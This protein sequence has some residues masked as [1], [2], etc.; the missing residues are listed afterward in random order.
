MLKSDVTCFADGYV[1]L[2]QLLLKDA[3]PS[4]VKIT[5]KSAQP[6]FDE[7]CLLA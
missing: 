6:V 3:E 5:L 2:A 4:I 1:Q 7:G